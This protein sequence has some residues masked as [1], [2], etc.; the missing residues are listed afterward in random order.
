VVGLAGLRGQMGWLAGGPIGPK[1]KEKFFFEKNFR[2]KI[3]F[4]NLARLWKIVE[5]D[6]GGILT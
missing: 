4:S 2:I 6:L 3:G 1:V 5:G